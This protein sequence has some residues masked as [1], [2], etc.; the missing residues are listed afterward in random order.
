M[1]DQEDTAHERISASLSALEGLIQGYSEPI[2]QVAEAIGRKVQVAFARDQEGAKLKSFWATII[3]VSHIEDS[4]SIEIQ[5]TPFRY[6]D[7]T[8]VGLRLRPSDMHCRPIIVEP[9]TSHL[10]IYDDVREFNFL[11]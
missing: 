1:S 2:E 10:N 3:G 5:V 11:T 7:I 6:C 4:D 8:I 9:G